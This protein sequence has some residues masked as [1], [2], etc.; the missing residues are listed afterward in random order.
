MTGTEGFVFAAAAV[1]LTGLLVSVWTGLRAG[2]V[3]KNGREGLSEEQEIGVTLQ[4]R[5]EEE[6]A[7][8]EMENELKE[9]RR[10]LRGAEKKEEG[11]SKQ[12]ILASET[13]EVQR[14]LS[15]VIIEKT[16]GATNALTEHVYS[17]AHSSRQVSNL[18]QEALGH[19]TVEEGGLKDDI[20][21]LQRDARGISGLIQEFQSIS[22]GYTTEME[23]IEGTMREVDSFT[24]SITDLA[25][26]TSVLA[27]NASIEAARAGHAGKG[28]AVIAS[29]VQ[30]LAGNTK[31][32]AE[33]INNTVENSVH[34]VRQSIEQ[35]GKRIENS[36]RQLEKSGEAHSVLI[37]KLTPQ[38]ENISRVVQESRELSETVTGD[39]NEV[40]VHLQYQDT[41]RQILEHMVEILQQ[42]THRE[43]ELVG[44]PG[45]VDSRE[46][47]N[48]KKELHSMV[49]S[50]F[51]TREEWQAFGYTLKEDLNNTDGKK[52]EES[53]SEEFEGDV[54]LF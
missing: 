43:R 13:V 38:I 7:G 53:S 25:E 17:L 21:Q 46:V 35:Y 2:N 33:Q 27:I 4:E 30:K 8:K 3:A 47:E 29:E 19:I 5:E 34:K 54:T 42:V 11:Y 28:F 52:R 12:C 26:R 41:V 48:L 23:T 32:I 14:T 44:D 39:L 49:K 18:I 6:R 50:L 15:R 16:E 24:D 31:S 37:E 9:L 1:S 20:E 10:R 22:D 36:V 45:E 40:T 51:T